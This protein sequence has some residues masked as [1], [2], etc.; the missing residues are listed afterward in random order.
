LKDLRHRECLLSA[1]LVTSLT[2][3]YFCWMIAS[4]RIEVTAIAL[5]TVIAGVALKQRLFCDIAAVGMA[6]FTACECG[7]GAIVVCALP[8]I[9]LPY[10]THS[11]WRRAVRN[12]PG[13]TAGGGVRNQGQTEG[14]TRWQK[15]AFADEERRSRQS[16][17]LE[18]MSALMAKTAK[19]DGRVDDGEIGAAEK[20]FARLGFTGEQRQT[21]IAAFRRALGE[22]YDAGFYA[23]RMVESGFSYEMR[24]MVY[25]LLWDVACANGSPV[26]ET[27]LV[28]RTIAARLDLAKGTFRNYYRQCVRR[29]WLEKDDPGDEPRRPSNPANGDELADEYGALGVDP[30]CSEEQ[31]KN[32]YRNLAKQMHPDALR[33]QGMP[34]SMLACANDRMAR[35]NAAWDRIRRARRIGG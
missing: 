2:V 19:A 25:E 15:L 4:A 21:C 20:A 31:L 18:L 34:E 5:L 9:L 3:C 27:A 14:P 30:G 29:P 12:R 1:T 33:S 16:S 28:L 32:A 17:Y 26:R 11:L 23:S 6:Y 35:I 7:P 13:A 22:P 24:V 8:A 10:F